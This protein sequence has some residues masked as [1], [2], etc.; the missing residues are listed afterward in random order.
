MPRLNLGVLIVPIVAI[1]TIYDLPWRMKMSDVNRAAYWQMQAKVLKEENEKLRW[2]L[3]REGYVRCD[4]PA[5][6]CESWHKSR[7]NK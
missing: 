3:I 7:G 4:S 6:N 2:F 1:P 5:C